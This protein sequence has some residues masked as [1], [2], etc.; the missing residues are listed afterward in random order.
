MAIITYSI[1]DYQN[2]ILELISYAYVTYPLLRIITKGNE[3]DMKYLCVHLYSSIVHTI[4]QIEYTQ[5]A[6]LN[7]IK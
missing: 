6:Q 2:L 5:M 1:D 7:I 4:Q 3:I